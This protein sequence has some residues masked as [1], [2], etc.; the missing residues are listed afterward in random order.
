M[1]VLALTSCSLMSAQAVCIEAEVLSVDKRVLHK[2]M[3][4]VCV[5][6]PGQAGLQ[7]HPEGTVGEHC[8][9]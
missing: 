3:L 8:V 6:V 7:T 5:C 9:G 2:V 4:H 1:S